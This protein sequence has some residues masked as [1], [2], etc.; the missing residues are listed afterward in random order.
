MQV[1]KCERMQDKNK[2]VHSQILPR[3]QITNSIC[4]HPN[5]NIMYITDG[6]T[7]KIR[8]Y[9]YD[10]ETGTLDESSSLFVHETRKG[11]YPD[12]SCVDQE[13]YIWNA[14]WSEQGQPGLVNRI[15]PS[16]GR[17][18]FTV[19]VGNNTTTTSQVSCCCFGGPDL[20][21]LFVTSAAVGTDPEK[22]PNAG[23]LY[24]VK[25]PF[26]GRKESRFVGT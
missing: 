19:H 3:I 26:K 18:V 13:G 25:L 20:D 10:K 12:G 16:T 24:A 17:V 5:G 6:P 22:E 21:I 15:D 4:F 23:A 14:L 8:S 7:R 2:L 11:G 1:F 9:P